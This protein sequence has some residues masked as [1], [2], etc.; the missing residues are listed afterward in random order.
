MIPLENLIAELQGTKVDIIAG[1]KNAE[2][3]R[4]ALETLEHGSDGVLL[5]TD[6]IST[7]KRAADVTIGSGIEN[8]SLEA[9]KI[10]KVIPVGMGDRV[11]VD[12]CSLLV[13]GEGMLV[14]SQSNGLFLVHAESEESP[15]VAARPFRVNAGAVHAYVLTGNKT[16]YLSELSSGEEILVVN[17]QGK[18]SKAVIGRVKIERRP[19][20]LVEAEVDGNKLKT[21]LQNAETIKLVK[22]DGNPISITELKEGDEVLVHYENAARHFGIR[23]DET[24]V[25]R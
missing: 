23:I 24:I 2:E 17:E 25:E 19:L 4:T 13:K 21:I 20:M 6:D 14:G 7:I 16:R 12:T 15:Y 5:D 11:C 1:V 22:K 18:T 3:A 8:L 9:A 10:T